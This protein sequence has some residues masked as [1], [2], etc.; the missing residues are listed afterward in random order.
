MAKLILL[1]S[2]RIIILFHLIVRI[3]QHFKNIQL[4]IK[5]NNIFFKI[6]NK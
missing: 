3:I 1:R 6:I 2:K 4:L 5:N